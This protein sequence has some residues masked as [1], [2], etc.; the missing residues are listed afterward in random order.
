M[1]HVFLWIW[2]QIN[3]TAENQSKDCEPDVKDK[4]VEVCISTLPG[5]TVDVPFYFASII[6]VRSTPF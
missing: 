2:P 4:K 6:S 1:H 3:K 5:T